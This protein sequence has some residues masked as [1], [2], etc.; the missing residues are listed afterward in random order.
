[1][2]EY[3]EHDKLHAVVDKSQAIGEF[4]EWLQSEKGVAF[5]GREHVHSEEE[6]GKVSGFWQCDYYKGQREYF[7]FD[8]TKLLSEFF[9]IDLKKLD[10]EKRAMLDEQRALNKRKVPA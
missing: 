3:P 1:M 8:I 2:A 4:C 5:M 9:D 6:C 7:H 10:N